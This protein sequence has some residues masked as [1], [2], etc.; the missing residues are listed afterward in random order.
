MIE[1]IRENTGFFIFMFLI[2]LPSLYALA[3]LAIEELY[4][5]W[6]IGGVLTAILF[7]TFPLLNLI[8]IGAMSQE[9]SGFRKWKYTFNKTRY[10]KSCG[11]YSY[12]GNTLVH[13]KMDGD[14]ELCPYCSSDKLTESTI[15]KGIMGEKFTVWSSIKLALF[16]M[17]IEKSIKKQEQ[18]DFLADQMQRYIKIEKQKLKNMNN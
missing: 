2:I 17:K 12:Y 13:E 16:I 6:S 14:L 10:C 9:D 1:T 4:N 11:I 8:M 18:N 5:K 3:A 15:S 7:S